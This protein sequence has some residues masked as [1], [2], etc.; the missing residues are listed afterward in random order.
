MGFFLT[1]GMSG[2]LTPATVFAGIL[3]IPLIV[4]KSALFIKILTRLKLRA[5]TALLATLNLSNYSEFGLIVVAVGV[6]NNWLDGDWLIVMAIALSVSFIISASLNKAGNRIYSKYNEVWRSMQR[7]TRLPDDILIDTKE[8][9]IAVFGM[10]R[11]GS[12][13]YDRLSKVQDK[14]VIGIDFD[15]ELIRKH[16]DEG[17]NAVIGNPGDPEFWE[18]INHNPPFELILLALPN[19]QSNLS[20]LSQICE[21]ASTAQIAAIVG[22]PDEEEILRSKGVSAVYNIY[23][24]SGAGFAEHVFNH[25]N[26]GDKKIL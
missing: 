22:Y 1:I 9:R 8:A 19:L 14:Q 13:A 7:T 23:S 11:V 2:E 18:K 25:I 17:R 4:I 10:G 5:R 21:I 15:P 16:T 6:S 3:F 24:D 26:S 20:A 12:G